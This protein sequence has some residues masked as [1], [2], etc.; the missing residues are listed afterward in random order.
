M[1]DGTWWIIIGG[2]AIIGAATAGV[3]ALYDPYMRDLKFTIIT[4]GIAG[5]AGGILGVTV[6]H[7]QRVQK[8]IDLIQL[9]QRQ[10]IQSPSIDKPEAK[11]DNPVTTGPAYI[12]PNELSFGYEGSEES[13][14][15]GEN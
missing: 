8:E 10:R 4:L 2:S 3:M 7:Y 11:I 6:V 5:L 14:F 12:I 9:I 15:R 13:M 1:L